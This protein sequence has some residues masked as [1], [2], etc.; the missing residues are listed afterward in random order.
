MGFI[1][2]KGEILRAVGEILRSVRRS[3]D[4]CAGLI[5]TMSSAAD[6]FAKRNKKK[7][8]KSTSLGGANAKALAPAAI[9]AAHPR[10]R[11]NAAE[12]Y[13][14]VCPPPPRLFVRSPKSRSHVAPR[15]LLWSLTRSD[16]GSL[17]APSS[18]E[19][20]RHGR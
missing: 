11:K 6:L 18:Q 15:L 5:P 14:S 20:A 13:R 17:P 7:G 1:S 8:K 2:R 19:R 9:V 16:N 3:C 4:L 10:Q 12:N